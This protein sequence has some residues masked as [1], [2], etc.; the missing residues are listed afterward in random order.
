M[1]GNW[2]RTLLSLLAVAGI[3]TG[4]IVIFP[5]IHSAASSHDVALVTVEPNNIDRFS[6]LCHTVGGPVPPVVTG[7]QTAG[8]PVPPKTV[9]VGP[10]IKDP[11]SS[12]RRTAG[13]TF[14][15]TAAKRPVPPVTVPNL[16]GIPNQTKS[17]PSAQDT[18]LVATRVASLFGVET[19][20]EPPPGTTTE[21]ALEQLFCICY[22]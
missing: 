11:F 20:E 9:S 14:Q 5:A 22:L 6:S 12:I 3:T 1:T 18:L 7:G 17:V 16:A 15:V 8:S 21:L 4:A 13:S 2:V 19:E 10:N